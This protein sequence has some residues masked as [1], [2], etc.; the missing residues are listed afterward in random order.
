MG[1]RVPSFSGPEWY[2][3]D[4]ISIE[5]LKGKYI[6]LDLWTTWC[7]PCI[8]ELPNIRAL[9][10]KV[11]TEKIAFIGVVGEDKHEK[12]NKI[13]KTTGINWPLVESNSKN[14]IFDK[15][16]VNSFPTTLLIDPNGIIIKSGFNT[17]GLEKYLEEYKLLN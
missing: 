16:K 7:G 17:Q 3:K 6:F 15:F 13:I 1:F 2:T 11:N 14:K 8:Q 9:Y 10:D 12:I 5:K 4:T